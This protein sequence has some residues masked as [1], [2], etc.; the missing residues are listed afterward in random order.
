[1]KSVLRSTL[2]TEACGSKVVRGFQKPLRIATM[3]P[4][5]IH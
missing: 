5:S 1:M 3:S 4:V 2:C